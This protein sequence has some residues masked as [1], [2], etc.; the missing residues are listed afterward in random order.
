M[1]RTLGLLVVDHERHLSFMIVRITS[2]TNGIHLVLFG[3][4]NRTSS[5]YLAAINRT[6]FHLWIPAAR[7]TPMLFTRHGLSF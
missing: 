1:H 6:S 5:P 3:M 7:G 2:E 4:Q